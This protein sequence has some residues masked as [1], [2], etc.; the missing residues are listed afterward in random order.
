MHITE[1]EKENFQNGS[2]TTDETIMLLEHLSNC[3]FCLNELIS[4]E[5]QRPTAS[6]PAYLQEQILK[7]AASPEI[8]AQKA[9]KHTSYRMQMFYCGL[10]A[11]TGVIVALFLLFT[12]GSVDFT[13]LNPPQNIHTE[14]REAPPSGR[15][16]SILS[17][18]SRKIHKGLTDGTEQVT[19][20]LNDIFN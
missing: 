2:M 3:D 19:D 18:F 7:K 5:E 6:A 11:A 16:G 13:S 1:Q 10:R 12:L 20:Y 14:A 4:N 15:R 8:Q 17:D 9:V